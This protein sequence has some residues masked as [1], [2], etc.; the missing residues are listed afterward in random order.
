[1]RSSRTTT[2]DSSLA[3]TPARPGHWS[4]TPAPFVSVPS[5]T[6][7]SSR[8]RWMRTWCTCRTRRS[9]ARMTAV[10]P[11]RP[12]TM[13]HTGTSTTSG[14]TPMTPRTSS[15][16]MTGA[17]PFRRIRVRV[18]LN[19]TSRPLSSIMPSRRRTYLITCVARSRTTARFAFPSTGTPRVSASVVAGEASEAGAAATMTAAASPRVRWTSPIVRGA[20]SPVTSRPTPRT[21]TFS[22]RA[23]TT[24]ATST[25][26]IAST[27]L[28]AR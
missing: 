13:G 20:V 4:T 7:T 10:R 22:T 3:T 6:P 14:S 11:T 21:S 28:R 12:S 2:V 24:A 18:G 26:S 25:S 19:R 27:A 1:M 9:S 15:S 17:G 23:R 8:T 5:T 16:G